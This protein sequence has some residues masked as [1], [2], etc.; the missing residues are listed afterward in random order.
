MEIFNNKFLFYN[1]RPQI[2]KKLATLQKKYELNKKKK[3]FV[4]I[5]KQKVNIYEKLK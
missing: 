5:K 4:S 2:K 1:E 3:L